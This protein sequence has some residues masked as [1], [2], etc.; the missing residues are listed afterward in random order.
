MMLLVKPS[1]SFLSPA[2][3]SLCPEMKDTV[4]GVATGN[5][6][7]LHNQEHT[8]PSVLHNGCARSYYHPAEQI[9]TS[10]V[11]PGAVCCLCDTSDSQ[12]FKVKK[13]FSVKKLLNLQL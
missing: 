3:P 12:P 9:L 4:L 5:S 6:Q 11:Y 8:Q 1:C 7:E 10:A 2:E 13:R